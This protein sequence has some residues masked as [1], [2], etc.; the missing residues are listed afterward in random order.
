LNSIFALRAAAR[1]VPGTLRPL[2]GRHRAITRVVV[3]LVSLAIATAISL[4]GA[5]A[6]PLRPPTPPTSILPQNVGVGVPTSQ[7]ITV[8]FA[9]PMD[10][11]SVQAAI[12]IRPAVPIRTAWRDR[13]QT[14]LVLPGLRWQTDARYVI[15]VAGT[16]RLTNGSELGT[17]QRVSF[18]TETAPLVSDFELHYVDQAA[19]PRMQALVDVG[20]P[21]LSDEI[22]P[23]DTAS[24]VST[25]T[26]ITIG[27]SAAMDRRD[28]ER[29]L[30]LSPQIPG[31]ISWNG[32]AL[33]FVPD[34]RLKPNA[35]YALMIAG[36]HDQAGNPL[37][38]DA[39]FS[40]T[41]R[42]GAQ[43]VK[44]SPLDGAKSLTNVQVAVWFS[45]AVDTAATGSAFRLTDAT[46]G[47]VIPG[48]V[49]WNPA[50]TQLRFGASHSLAKGH[51]FRMSF[52][53]GAHD[54]DGN[55][56]S[57]TW[58][59]RTK[60]PPPP[61]PPAARASAPAPRRTPTG[62]PPPSDQVQFALW[63]INQERAARGI[64]PLSLNSAISAVASAHAWDMIN[65]GY[66]SHTGRDGSTV[67]TRMRRAGISFSWSGE[68]LCYLGGNS[69]HSTL[70][71]CHS[72]FMSEPYPGYANHIG[73]ILGTHY[74]RVGIGIAQS[75]A[76]IIVVWDFAG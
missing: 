42:A 41:T 52:A 15:T 26:S 48:K 28:V 1:A 72:T 58:S 31:S 16:A 53:K 50:R 12:S 45:Q 66:F 24:L 36:A 61:P 33:T 54:T 4:Q 55:V 23:P 9:E 49:V 29:R 74:S 18:T 17:P 20:T 57:G 27:F 60:A 11:G 47:K 46:T 13:G 21:P 67:S 38:G 56:V 75:G 64:A 7:A 6:G 65:Y 39:S 5:S 70:Q 44:V 76:K 73:N 10:L 43:A 34:G 40:F 25:R 69:L 14:L 19:E 59:F 63:Q 71:W 3:A 8:T 51:T 62:P 68:N 32:N 30:A 37:G 35:R 22:L 2:I